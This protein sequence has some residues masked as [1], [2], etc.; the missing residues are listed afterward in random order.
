MLGLVAVSALAALVISCGERPGVEPTVGSGVG[1]TADSAGAAEDQAAGELDAALAAWERFPAQRR[2]RPIVLRDSLPQVVG[3]TTDEAKIAALA[4]DLELTGPL[5]PTPAT[6]TARL[7]DGEVT[8]PALPVQEAL[9]GIRDSGDGGQNPAGPLRITT[10]ELGSARF[11]TDR[12]PLTLP[13]WLFHPVDAL[14][15]LA[16]PALA[17]DSFW[18]GP[19][20]DTPGLAIGPDATLASDG[21]TITVSLPAPPYPCPGAAVGRHEPVVAESATAVAVGFRRIEESPAT[22]PSAVCAEPA[23]L[24][25]EPHEVQLAQPLGDRV[26]IGQDGQAVIVVGG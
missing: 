20:P 7:P 22:D 1:P 8:L 2:P 14:G 21:R 25:F 10:V 6:V 24:R 12:G 4:G 9:D 26:L 13:A 3:F 19:R 15:P 5:P 16:W 18:P 23:M 17:A 11:R